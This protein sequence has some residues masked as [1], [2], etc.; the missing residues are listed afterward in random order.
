MKFDPEQVP[1]F[2]GTLAG[3]F[4]F[5]SRKSSNTAKAS[6]QQQARS[7]LAPPA[8]ETLQ[9][10]ALTFLHKLARMSYSA[11]RITLAFQ[12][13]S[14]GTAKLSA[15]ARKQHEDV[16]DL[17]VVAADIRAMAEKHADDMGETATRVEE[18]FEELHG[19]NDQLRSTAAGFEEFHRSLAGSRNASRQLLQQT[20]EA[21]SLIASVG[22]IAKQTNLLALNAAIEAARAGEAGKSFSVVADEVRKLAEQSASVASRVNGL[23]EEIAGEAS[24]TAASLD[25]N[26]EELENYGETLHKTCRDLDSIENVLEKTSANN[27]KVA[28]GSRGLAGE[29]ERIGEKVTSMSRLVDR[30]VEVAQTVDRDITDEQS[31]LKDLEDNLGTF[32]DETAILLQ[33]SRSTDPRPGFIL[34]T[35]P[36]PPFIIY[37]EVREELD[38]I[39][40]RIAREVCKRL[41]F[42]LTV[43]FTTWNLSL[44]LV[45]EGLADLVP[46]I[47]L[48]EERSAYLNFTPS[49]RSVSRYVLY[50]R[51]DRPGTID[52]YGDLK[53][54]TV[55][56]MKGHSLDPTFQADSTIPKVLCRREKALFDK[57]EKGQ[58]EAVL[59]NEY[60]GSYFMNSNETAFGNL[61]RKEPFHFQDQDSDTRFGF[62]KASCDDDRFRDFNRVLA[63]MYNDG[64]I[65]EMERSYLER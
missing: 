17:E 14:S 30:V 24:H 13:I 42:P 60:S 62:S 52:S 28:D 16:A 47:S 7:S 58:I 55:G 21:I 64:T 25:R 51:R 27:R 39:D 49:Y 19:K 15:E 22:I 4:G 26:M 18:A 3:I 59:I 31:D 11:E 10:S 36:Y 29:T 1:L 53:G 5:A 41:K 9:R 50:T 40:I 61:F 44:R 6:G 20:E 57:L 2:L 46:T 45:K 35:S 32:E 63:E 65:D 33:Q 8:T 48:N 43:R 23:I 56:I 34:A 54:I 12:D 38:G 37:D